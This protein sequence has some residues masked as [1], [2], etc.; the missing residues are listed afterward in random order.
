MNPVHNNNNKKSLKHCEWEREKSMH[1]SDNLNE[2]W[3]LYVLQT[4]EFQQRST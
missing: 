2:L 3:I 4:F 1:K